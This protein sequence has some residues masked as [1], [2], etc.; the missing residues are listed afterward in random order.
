MFGAWQAGA[1][2]ALEKKLRPDLVVGCSVGA[3][4]GYSVACGASGE[5]LKK[6]WLTRELTELGGL[7]ANLRRMT[8]EFQ[9]KI[10][11]GVTVTDLRR[12]KPV[13]F[14]NGEITWRHMLAS[15]AVPGLFAPVKIDGRLYMDGGLLNNVP[16]WAA[17][18]MGATHVIG[19]NALPDTPGWW[20]RPVVRGFRGVVGYKPPAKGK[21][22]VQI[23][24]PH[25]LLG[26]PLDAVRWNED[27]SRRWFEQGMEDA[28]KTI[29]IPNCS[30]R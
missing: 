21:V 29:S 15:C 24:S 27:Y 25:R 11:L 17:I 12:M 3:L 30:E 14:Q 18:E 28:E 23:V 7:A 8:K 2:Y 16:A 13:L 19:L 1:W 10:P 20:L 22:D 6:M 4:N 5:R 9:P 26:G